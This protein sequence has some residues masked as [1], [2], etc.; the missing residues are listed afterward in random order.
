VL[1]ATAAAAQ[2]DAIVPF[3]VQVPNSVLSDL[4]QRLAHARI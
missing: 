1:V 4:K 3:K 2:P